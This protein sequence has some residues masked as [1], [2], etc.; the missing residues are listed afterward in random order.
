MLAFKV[1]KL[2]IKTIPIIILIICFAYR[3]TE[4]FDLDFKNALDVIIPTRVNTVRDAVL[5]TLGWFTKYSVFGQSEFLRRTNFIKCPRE[6]KKIKGE[7]SK[8]L[9]EPVLMLY[10]KQNSSVSKLYANETI[11]AE[12]LAKI[13]FQVNQ[14]T[15]LLFPGWYV[16]LERERWLYQARDAILASYVEGQFMP[17]YFIVDW[18]LLGRGTL[19]ASGTDTAIAGRRLGKLLKQI[20]DV[21][22]MSPS[23]FHCL[24]HSLGA[25]GCG[26]AARA[27][28]GSRAGELFGRITALDAAGFCYE[29]N[30][31]DKDK[32]P[33]MRPS[34][35]LVTDA[36]VSNKGPFGAS[37]EYA[38]FNVYMNNA[39]KQSSCDV[40]RNKR[41]GKRYLQ[42]VLAF[43]FKIY[44]ENETISCDHFVCTRPLGEVRSNSCSYIGVACKSYD[45]FSRGKCAIGDKDD[46]CLGI[47]CYSMDNENHRKASNSQRYANSLAR[48]I[49]LLKQVDKGDIN[50]R[51]IY[52]MHNRKSS[53]LCSEYRYIN[54][55]M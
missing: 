22:G 41:F 14:T 4:A 3:A 32:F 30:V 13:N 10:T 44:A 42:A 47:A 51:R 5:D 18:S 11:T 1:M 40:V 21:T 37:F 43:L 49:E 19:R 9:H 39:Y 6:G 34:D 52:Y 20:V 12:R 23:H 15:F 8:H 35:A 27:A 55:Y 46:T 50:R 26:Q 29:N 2:N 24:G 38:K 54:M 36:F 25:H 28:F 48:R 33:G 53:P 45:D 16:D 17:N 7:D 31:F